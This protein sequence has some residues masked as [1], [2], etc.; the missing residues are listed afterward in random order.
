MEKR[1]YYANRI[2]EGAALFF[3]E[4]TKEEANIIYEFLDKQNDGPDSGYSGILYFGF[5]NYNE[6]G[7]LIGFETRQEAIDYC[8]E[9]EHMLDDDW[10]EWEHPEEEEE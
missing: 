7:E 10:E 6:N 8:K 1:W 9:H 5:G 4:L 2:G 3:V